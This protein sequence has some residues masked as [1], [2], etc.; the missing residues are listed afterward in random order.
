MRRK[1]I[2]HSDINLYVMETIELFGSAVDNIFIKTAQR[3]NRMRWDLFSCFCTCLTVTLLLQA[4]PLGGSNAPMKSTLACRTGSNQNTLPGAC[5]QLCLYFHLCLLIF[6][7]H[8]YTNTHRQKRAHHMSSPPPLPSYINKRDA[9]P[10]FDVRKHNDTPQNGKT[11]TLP[12]VAGVSDVCATGKANLCERDSNQRE[13][14]PLCA[15]G[16]KEHMALIT[17]IPLS[18]KD[19]VN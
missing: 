14:L 1:N 18:P 7:K 19:R 9:F 8:M 13:Q 5:N 11:R 3:P 2:E 12:S 10:L 15:C 17:Q 4:Y 6:A 16:S